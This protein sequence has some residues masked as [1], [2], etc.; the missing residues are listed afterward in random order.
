MKK[1]ILIVDDNE[2]FLEEIMELLLLSGYAPIITS[3]SITVLEQAKKIKPDLVLLDLKMKEKDGFQVARELKEC[4]ETRDIPIIAMTGYYTDEQ[5]A[6]LINTCRVCKCLKKPFN[7]LDVI[8]EIE[9][10]FQ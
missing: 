3:E 4:P 5:Y 8:S 9:Q 1:I 6:E 7:P 10:I 2:D